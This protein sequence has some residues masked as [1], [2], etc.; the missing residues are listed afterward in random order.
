M[1]DRAARKTK[2][3][4]VAA[5]SLRGRVPALSPAH[6]DALRGFFA[7]Q[8]HWLLRDGGVLR[9]DAGRAGESAAD[10]FALDADG[11]RLALRFDAASESQGN[12][13]LRWNDHVGRSRVLAWSLAHET[14]LMRLSDAL[15]VSLLPVADGSVGDDD[16]VWLDFTVDDYADD[17]SQAPVARIRG[18]LR[19][20]AGWLAP[21][22]ERAEA[23]FAEEPAPLPAHWRRLPA[24]VSLAFAIPALSGRDWR[25][26]RPGDAIVVGR[27]GRPP[28]LQARAAGRFWPLAQAPSG[29]RVEGGAQPL[30]ANP[31][32]SPENAKMSENDDNTAVAEDPARS[33]PV[34]VE[35]EIGQVEL[36]LG[37]LADLQPGYVFALPA[38]LEGANVVIRANGR[39]SGRG[40][41]VAVGETLGVRLLSWS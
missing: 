11:T 5:A 2:P 33:L 7:H 3:R 30:P 21:L 9:F 19:V 22:A 12:D 15:G 8:R 23:S 40:E 16:G 4:P 17:D 31:S 32:S 10:I 1:A 28:A 35:F 13:G 27:S 37:E 14:R 6:A 38:H 20:P 36:S 26:L 25:A 18:A 39:A 41:V 34:R 24:T 29:W